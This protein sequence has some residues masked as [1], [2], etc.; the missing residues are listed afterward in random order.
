VTAATTTPQSTAGSQPW[1]EADGSQSSSRHYARAG[2]GEHGSW[3]GSHGSRY[4]G[5]PWHGGPGFPGQGFGFPGPGGQG[6]P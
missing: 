1:T 4:S 5:G 6:R 3:Y 2:S